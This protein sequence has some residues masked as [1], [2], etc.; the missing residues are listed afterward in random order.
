MSWWA[1]G[2]QGYRQPS[3]ARC[4]AAEDEQEPIARLRYAACSFATPAHPTASRLWP[5]RSLVDELFGTSNT[6]HENH[7]QIVLTAEGS[8][9]GKH[10]NAVITIAYPIKS[11]RYQ[12]RLQRDAIVLEITAAPDEHGM[13]TRASF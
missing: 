5:P 11:T 12:G 3:E 7:K 13:I 1:A 9:G 8:F 2:N 4:S 6:R 10:H